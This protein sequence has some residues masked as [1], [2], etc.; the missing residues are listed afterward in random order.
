M[1]STGDR[2]IDTEP[3]TA[4]D[5][6]GWVSGVTV[7]AAPMPTASCSPPVSACTWTSLAPVTCEPLITASVPLPIMFTATAPET[8][9]ARVW[10]GLAARVIAA[11]PLAAVMSASETARTDSEA[12]VGEAVPMSTVTPSMRATVSMSVMFT[13]ALPAPDSPKVGG[14]DAGGLVVVALERSRVG[15]A[16]E[17]PSRLAV[18]SLAAAW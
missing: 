7:I 16:A 2:V 11:D 15:C 5:E 6:I 13:A 12:G 17:S 1:P 14:D 3:A 18:R 10:L 8:P 9:T 4:S